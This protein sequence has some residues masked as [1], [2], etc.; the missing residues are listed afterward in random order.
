MSCSTTSRIG[1]DRAR[2]KDSVI[3]QF[4]AQLEEGGRAGAWQVADSRAVA[5][6]VFDGMHT[7]VDDAIAT[8]WRDPEPLIHLLVGLFARLLHV[9]NPQR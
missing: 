7:V 3:S 4:V 5:L 2:E 1:A 8:G 9:D 6:I